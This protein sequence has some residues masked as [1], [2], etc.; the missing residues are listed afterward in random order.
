MY[1]QPIKIDL[2]AWKK[3]LNASFWIVI[4][5]SIETI[6]AIVVGC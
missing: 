1:P 5:L 4:I 6:V 3:M 2:G